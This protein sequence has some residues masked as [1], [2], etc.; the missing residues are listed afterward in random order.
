M[1]LISVMIDV[2]SAM[3][4]VSFLQLTPQRA[5]GTTVP[6]WVA[7]DLNEIQ[8]TVIGM[9]SWSSLHE[10]HES[11]TLQPAYCLYF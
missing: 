7:A 6:R 11:I 10:I 1:V 8:K 9:L 5:R 2:S 4:Y 3:S